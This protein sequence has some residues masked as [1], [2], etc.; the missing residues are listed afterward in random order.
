MPPQEQGFERFPVLAGAQFS[1]S[2]AMLDVD[3]CVETC[4]FMKMRF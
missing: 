4:A 2:P 3:R 1:I